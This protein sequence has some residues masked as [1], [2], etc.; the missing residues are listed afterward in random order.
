MDYSL[1]K[2]APNS[3]IR[4]GTTVYNHTKDKISYHTFGPILDRMW[5]IVALIFM[6][7]IETIEIPMNFIY[8]TLD[9][10]KSNIYSFINPNESISEEKKRFNA[11]LKNLIVLP[12]HLVAITI[13]NITGIFFPN[14]AKQLIYALDRFFFT[15]YTLTKVFFD[16]TE[17][18]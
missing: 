2:L 13:T 18:D 3:W 10:I 15:Y 5:S 17:D 8:S 7:I 14:N 6:P 4:D 16:L 12:F 1:F 11:D 9:L